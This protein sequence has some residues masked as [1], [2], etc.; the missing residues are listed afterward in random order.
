MLF[1]KFRGAASEWRHQMLNKYL[2]KLERRFGKFTIQGLMLF[3][4]I[5]MGAVYIFDLVLSMK[6][7]NHVF[8]QPL[9]TF[10]LDAI[11]H[12]QIWRVISFLLVPPFASNIIFVAFELYFLWT[13]GEGL[14]HQWGSFK[15][16]IY[17]LI[18]T[19]G[20]IIAGFIT[21]YADNGFLNLS[22]F[23]AFAIL[24]PNFEILL[25]FILP[26]KIK[27]LGIIDGLFMLY[28]F[29]T[30]DMS[31]KLMLIV[32]FAN[33]ILFFGKDFFSGIYYFFRRYYHKWFKNK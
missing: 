28:L 19:I 22:L 4:V 33:L 11:K 6:P 23:L 31:S 13:F 16:N 3:I 14:E 7:D 26:I 1:V 27:W 15:F 5:G 17:Y 9:L 18:G 12:G 21:G 2:D 20:T 30:G 10:D 24:Y 25:F 8:I 29:I 32:A